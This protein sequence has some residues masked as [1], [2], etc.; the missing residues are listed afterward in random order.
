MLL[1]VLCK[2]EASKRCF[3]LARKP[4]DCNENTTTVSSSSII[5]DALTF[6]FTS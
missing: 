5:L 6:E 4:I 2:V 3:F 1:L